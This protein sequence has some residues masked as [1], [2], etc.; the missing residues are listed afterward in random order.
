LITI[1]KLSLE[2]TYLGTRKNSLQE[3]LLQKVQTKHTYKDIVSIIKT[4]PN[5]FTP[6]HLRPQKQNLTLIN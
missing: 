5:N 1:R 3:N 2:Q 6:Q 4:L